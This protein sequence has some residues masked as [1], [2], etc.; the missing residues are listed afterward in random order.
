MGLR[1]V[2][3]SGLRLNPSQI[4]VRNVMRLFDML[5]AF[6]L[7]GGIACVWNRKRQ[8]LGDLVAGTAVIRVPKLSEPDLSQLEAGRQNSLARE[9]HLA[10]RLRQKVNPQI[11]ESRW[12]HCCAAKLWTRI[13]ASPYSGIW[14]LL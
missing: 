8:R 4:V 14:R 7:V 13:R 2:E 10:A 12:K 3:A 5:P 6:Y 11:A 9:R 1:V